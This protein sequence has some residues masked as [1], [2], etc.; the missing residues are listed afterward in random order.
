MNVLV[1]AFSCGPGWG[2][3][4]GIGWNTVEQIS[5]HHRVWVLVEAG[6]KD[7]VQRNLDAA[8]HPDIHFVW[9]RIPGLDKLV[10]GGPLNFGLGWLL[11]Y[12][13]WQVV[14]LKK[15]RELHREVRFDL[16]HHVTFGKYSVPSHLHRLG[17]P[18]IFGPVGGAEKAPT[19]EF[20]GDFGPAAR[21]AERF[22]LAHIALA[23]FDPWL[24][25][26]ARR[27]ALAIGTTEESAAELRRIGAAHVDV[28]PAISLPDDETAMLGTFTQTKA[29][30]A[31]SLVF[32]G[33][34]LAWKGVHLAIRGLASC[35]NADLT[36]RII[37][38]GP[39]RARLVELV[40]SLG[41]ENRVEF[42]GNLPRTEV[43]KCLHEADGLLFPSLHDSG[44]YA[45]IESMAAALPVICLDLGGPGMFVTDECGWKVHAVEP[46]QT[47][48]A[49]AEAL[50]AFADDPAERERRGTQARARCLRHFTA[51]SHGAKVEEIYRSLVPPRNEVAG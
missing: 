11:Y 37:G 47:V 9:I 16:V 48:R 31:P 45:V 34:L 26:C 33:R 46:K 4:P 38:D 27:A 39:A 5:R 17:I 49:L 30:S 13:L 50:D 44:G 1:S 23:R 42:S 3:E 28:L 8:H 18:L 19:P 20:Y 12:M 10:D 24:R 25:S 43:L 7:R 6:W 51:S 36:L 41:L 14:A 22:R 32:I 2:S 35:R 21:L 29:K 15:A 40:A